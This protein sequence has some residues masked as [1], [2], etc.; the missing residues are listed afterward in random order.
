MNKYKEFPNLNELEPRSWLIENIR[1]IFPKL[2]ELPINNTMLTNFLF[3]DVPI[4]N[5]DTKLV[6]FLKIDRNY[7]RTHVFEL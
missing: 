4:P 1:N 3:G 2:F 7:R 5:R 6:K